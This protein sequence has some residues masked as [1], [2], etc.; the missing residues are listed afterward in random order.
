MPTLLSTRRPSVSLHQAIT[1]T[2]SRGMKVNLGID[3]GL[4]ATKPGGIALAADGRSR[5]SPLNSL[6]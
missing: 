4:T 3:A 5:L 6:G 1:R 2:H